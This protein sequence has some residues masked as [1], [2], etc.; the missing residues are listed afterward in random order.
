[1]KMND[2]K[3]LLLRSLPGVDH[4]LELTKA[5]PYFETVPRTVLTHSI[6]DVIEN[7]RIEILKTPHEIAQENL[8]DTFILKSV[9]ALT[10]KTLA[11]KRGS[12]FLV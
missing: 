1:M 8:T 9:K 2:R 12:G 11:P 6:R 3:Q 7:L 10:Q 4:I 5:D